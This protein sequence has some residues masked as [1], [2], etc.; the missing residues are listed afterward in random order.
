[1]TL[2]EAAH[3]AVACTATEALSGLP[4]WEFQS[5][6]QIIF[7]P[8]P[9]CPVARSRVHDVTPVGIVPY[10]F[11]W[12]SP[13][14]FGRV[15]PDFTDEPTVLAMLPL[16]RR[17]WAGHVVDLTFHANGTVDL[18]IFKPQQETAVVIDDVPLYEALTLA[19]E[20]APEKP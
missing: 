19:L 15:C 7:T 17:A 10:G 18:L 9:Q 5:G 4:K 3:R 2:E 8:A 20:A 12:A 16:V 13:L 11:A 6:M 1:M 14:P